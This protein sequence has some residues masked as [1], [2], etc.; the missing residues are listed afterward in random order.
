VLF[1]SPSPDAPLS[2]ARLLELIDEPVGPSCWPSPFFV[3]GA[4][5]PSQLQRLLAPEVVKQI[6]QFG[7]AEA[8]EGAR[9]GERKGLGEGEGKGET[10]LEKGFKACLEAAAEAVE[11]RKEVLTE[12]DEKV[13]DGDCGET[14]SRGASSLLRA[15]RAHRLSLRR[16]HLAFQQMS[17]A[18]Q[19]DMGGSSGLPPS[20]FPL[21]S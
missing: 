3:E 4:L 13:G 17:Q 2:A 14:L 18:I 8:E 5:P 20:S 21:L 7:E 10:E 6:P 11:E 16:P 12:M 15:L 9:E 19:A 1:R